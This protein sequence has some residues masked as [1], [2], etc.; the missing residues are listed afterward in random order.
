M[1]EC[2]WYSLCESTVP[3]KVTILIMLIFGKLSPGKQQLSQFNL[4]KA[5]TELI[6]DIQTSI[7][8][9]ITDD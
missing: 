2:V 4:R 9:R 1:Y 8:Y 5:S 7:L 3:P 6:T